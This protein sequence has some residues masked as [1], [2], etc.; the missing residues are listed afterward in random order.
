MGCCQIKSKA[1]EGVGGSFSL[2]KDQLKHLKQC[3]DNTVPDFSLDGLTVWGKVVNVYDGDTFR[4]SFYMNPGDSKT[5]KFKV[6]G[7]G[8]NAPEIRPSKD[9]K[10]REEEIHRAVCARN[11]FIQLATDCKIEL[12]KRYT[13]NEIQEIVDQNHKLIFIRFDKF[14]KYGRVLADIFENP[15]TKKSIN[16]ILIDEGHA[17]PYHGEGRDKKVLTV[18]ESSI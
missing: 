17:V 2:T 11:R 9:H 18:G 4:I 7:N 5:V 3:D 15:K 12:D 10:N 16:Q 13:R 6:R 14:E 1:K 8:Y